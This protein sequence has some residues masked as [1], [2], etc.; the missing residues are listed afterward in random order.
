MLINANVEDAVHATVRQKACREEVNVMLCASAQANHADTA[1]EGVVARSTTQI[2][3][4]V[5]RGESEE[6]EAALLVLRPGARGLESS[7]KMAR[8]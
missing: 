6:H 3:D 8:F 1:P 7:I 4:R 2:V 5:G